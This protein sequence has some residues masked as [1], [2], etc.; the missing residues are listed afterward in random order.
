MNKMI[1]TT[2]ENVYI[3]RI[4]MGSDI[5]KKFY[6]TDGVPFIRGIN[7]SLTYSK[8]KEEGYVFVDREIAD[9]LSRYSIIND[10]IFTRKGTIGQ[11]GIIPENSKYKEYLIS[12]SQFR[13]RVDSSKVLPL[14]TYYWLI[15]PWIQKRLK[16]NIGSIQ[17][18]ITTGEIDNLP[19]EYPEDIAYQ[20]KVVDLI[21]SLSNKIENNNRINDNLYALMKLIYENMMSSAAKNKISGEYQPIKSLVDIITGK[22]D[23]NFATENGRYKFFTCSQ[24]TFYCDDYVFDNPSILIAGNG[25]FSVKHYTGKF[26]AYQRV[27][28]LSPPEDYYAL[29]YLSCLYRVSFL[30]NSSIGSIV[31]FITKGDIEDIPV[32]IPS[33]KEI[34][35]ELN[36]L[37]KLIEQNNQEIEKLT[38]LREWLLPM[39][40]NGQITIS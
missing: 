29:I 13:V 27:Y 8:L 23:A 2:L 24:S 26:N 32:F 38:N 39:L 30:K 33:N 15:T 12:T 9:K 36:S 40:M 18:G 4:Q 34:L 17:P 5:Q 31:K 6:K 35:F 3:C 14:Y 20:Q 11:V 7:L 22:Q 21:E 28:V 19:I 25:D 37:L 1:K 16:G 10:I